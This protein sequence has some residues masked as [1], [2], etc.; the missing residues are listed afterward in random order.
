MDPPNIT[1]NGIMKSLNLTS[2]QAY[3]ALKELTDAGKL[4]KYGRGEQA[5]WKKT[6]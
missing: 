2:S 5:V 1:K 3:F 6:A 4:K